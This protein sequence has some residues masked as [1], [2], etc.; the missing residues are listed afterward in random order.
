MKKKVFFSVLQFIGYPALYEN[1]TP[2]PPM[3]PKLRTAK[4]KNIN[5]TLDRMIKSD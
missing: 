2:P 3:I 1:M 4:S 5:I